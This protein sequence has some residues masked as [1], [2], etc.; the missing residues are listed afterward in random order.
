MKREAV[1]KVEWIRRRQSASD[2]VATVNVK[3]EKTLVSSNGRETC[4]LVMRLKCL[5]EQRWSLEGAAD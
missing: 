5:V 2:I 3:E 1:W 4:T